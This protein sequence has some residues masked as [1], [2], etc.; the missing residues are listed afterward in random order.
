M[1]KKTVIVIMVAS[2]KALLKIL[3]KYNIMTNTNE[4]QSIDR[5]GAAG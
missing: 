4:G 3:P 5:K 1:Y 2:M